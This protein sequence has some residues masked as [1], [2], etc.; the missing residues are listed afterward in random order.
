MGEDAAAANSVTGVMREMI[1]CLCNGIGN[2]AAI[3]VGNELGAGELEKGRAYGLKLKNISWVIGLGSSL[4]VVAVTP[5]LQHIVKLDDAAAHYLTG[6]MLITAF[7]MIGRCINTITING[8]LDGGGDTI[9]DFVSL[10]IS[11]W[12][13]AVPLA[14]CGAFVFGWHVLA[15]YACTCLDEVGKIPWVMARVR[16]YKWVRNLTK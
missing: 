7:Y 15:V 11:M 1:A 16:K 12:L 4:V 9:F 13:I 8:V 3:M 6:M 10:L 5:L 2:A 14:V